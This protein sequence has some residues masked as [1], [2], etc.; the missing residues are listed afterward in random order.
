MTKI[1]T[2]LKENCSFFVTL[3]SSDS[4]LQPKYQQKSTE[5]LSAIIAH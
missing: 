5:R 3:T 2:I 4:I 1:L